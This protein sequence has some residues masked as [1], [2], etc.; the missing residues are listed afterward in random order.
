MSELASLLNQLEDQY[1]REEADLAARQANVENLR[2]QVALLKQLI[3]LRDGHSDSSQSAV[4][5]S[6]TMSATKA[7]LSDLVRDILDA[8]GEPM[9]IAMIRGALIAQGHSI[10]GRGTDANVIAH[11]S[12]NDSIVRVGKGTYALASWGLPAKPKRRRR[13]KT[14]ARRVRKSTS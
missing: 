14:R 1:Q 9:H 3:A 12:R 5:P 2:Q 6:L 7:T 11:I 10:P 4:D 8:H 13:S